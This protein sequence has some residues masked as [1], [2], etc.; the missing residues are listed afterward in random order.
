MRKEY[1]LK[2][3]D[4]GNCAAKIEGAVQALPKVEEAHVQLVSKRLTVVTEDTNIREDVVRLIGKIEPGIEVLDCGQEKAE[5]GNYWAGWLLLGEAVLFALGLVWGGALGSWSWL[6]FLVLYLALGYRVLLKMLKNLVRGNVFDENFL[7]SVATLGAL[8]LGEYPEAVAVMLFYQV[9]EFFQ[10]RAIEQSRASISSLM[11]IRP[12]YAWKSAGDSWEKVAPDQVEVG[13]VILVKPG[14]KIPLDGQVVEGQ[15]SLNTATL[16]GESLPQAVEQGDGVLSGSINLTSPLLITVSKPFEESTVQRILELVQESS[17]KKSQT[18]QFITRFSRRYTPVVTFLALLI[19]VIP[20]LLG[21]GLWSDWVYRA[22]T[23]LVIACPC[24]LAVSVPLT[25]FGGLGGASRLGALVKGGNYLE[26]LAQAET[27]VFDKTGT[28]TE[29]T[30]SLQKI[31]TTGDEETLLEIAAHIEGHSNHPIAQSIREAYGKDLDMTRLQAAEEIPGKGLRARVDGQSFLLGNQ[32]L[33]EEAGIA[34]PQRAEVGT[35]LYLAKE[36]DYQGYLLLADTIKSS[37]FEAIQ[38]L[39]RIGVERLAVLSGDRTEVVEQVATSLNIDEAHGGCL[40]EDKLTLFE[41]IA[42]ETEGK[43][44]FIGDGINDAP[45]LA[46]ADL[47]VGMGAI[48]SDAAIEAADVVLMKDDLSVLPQVM[49]LSRKTLRIAKQNI[50]LALAVKGLFLA[51]GVVG[52]STMWEAI[53]SDVGV[54]V[55]AVLNA[56][57]TLRIQ[58]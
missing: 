48:G 23:F 19:G 45:V 16:T 13:E 18:E 49:Q 27:I 58:S 51:L 21:L 57:R 55:I 28:L 7:M 1:E 12:D 41:K 42:S 40:P 46:K 9:G 4:C 47:G 22:L 24:A 10:D 36:G 11:D 2:G 50:L 52:I 17:S 34:L 25:F 44:V 31:V 14:E 29:G 32:A 35:V 5:K 20:P 3:L 26:V 30:F 15:S 33:C 43:T 37:S 6:Y 56:L 38:E 54:T 39:K 8:V 53:F